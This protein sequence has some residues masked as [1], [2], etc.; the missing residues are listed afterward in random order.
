MV[1]I[2]KLKLDTFHLIST[3]EGENTNGSRNRINSKF[4]WRNINMR[5][6]LGEEYKKYNTFKL[7]LYQISSR[8]TNIDYGDNFIDKKVQI[9]VSGLDWLNCNYEPS[10]KVNISEAFISEYL[11]PDTNTETFE[12]PK[13]KYF[14]KD[15]SALIFSKNA[16]IDLTMEYYNFLD[17]T[18][19]STVQSLDKYPEMTF[20]F[21]I[22]GIN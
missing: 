16:N 17:D 3:T 9:G 22:T 4:T 18:I 13:F 5:V 20:Y 19:E 15:I 7:V 1:L 10:E 2:T 14:H 12:Y 11:F 8:G 21:N 6:L